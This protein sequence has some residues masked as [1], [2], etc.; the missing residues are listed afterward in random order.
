MPNTSSALPRYGHFGDKETKGQEN[1][2]A[3]QPPNTEG[4]AE[5]PLGSPAAL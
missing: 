1:E 3:A 2:A 4:G 5:A